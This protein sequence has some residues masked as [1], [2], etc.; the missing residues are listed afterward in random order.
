MTTSSSVLVF[1]GTMPVLRLGARGETPRVHHTF[2]G[3]HGRL[4]TCGSRATKHGMRRIGVLIQVG[5]NGG[6]THKPASRCS[7]RRSSNWVGR[8]ARTYDSI[9]V[10]RTA[11]MS[12]RENSQKNSSNLGRM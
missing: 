8:T 1:A 11:K 12:A 9:F 4:A 7:K 3:C 6:V 5:D 10:G 2:W